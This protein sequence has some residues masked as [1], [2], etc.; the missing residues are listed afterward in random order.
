MLRRPDGRPIRETRSTGARASGPPFFVCGTPPRAAP[1]PLTMAPSRDPCRAFTLFELVLVVT[2]AAIVAAAVGAMLARAGPASRV[3]HA[4]RQAVTELSSARLK[5]MRSGGAREAVLR[6]SGERISLERG[7]GETR[8]WR[9]AGV[10][11]MTGAAEDDP[12]ALSVR[13]R[14]NGRTDERRWRFVS[15]LTGDTIWTIEFDPVSGTPRLL[16]P[17]EAPGRDLS[18]TEDTP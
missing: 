6:F 1:I 5:A 10:S 15:S 8:D 17:G 14:A 16:P 9:G 18:R 3:T 4:L 13:F 12:G 11:P 7:G 2:I